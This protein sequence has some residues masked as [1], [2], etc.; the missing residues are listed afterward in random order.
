MIKL[1]CSFGSEI[2]NDV[3]KNVSKDKEAVEFILK[4]GVDPN[5]R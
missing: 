4:A 2:T 1:L 5:F 3:F